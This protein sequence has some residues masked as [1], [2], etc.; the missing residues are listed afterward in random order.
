MEAIELIAAL[1][2]CIPIGMTIAKFDNTRQTFKYVIWFL[3]YIICLIL[4]VSIKTPQKCIPCGKE[5]KYE[6]VTETFYRKI[7]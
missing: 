6:Q 5:S 7:K 3:V 4:L 1:I 2:L